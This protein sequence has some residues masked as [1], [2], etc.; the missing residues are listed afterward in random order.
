MCLSDPAA[1]KQSQMND[2]AIYFRLRRL[3]NAMQNTPRLQCMIRYIGIELRDD[4]IGA[5]QCIA[6]M[7]M[8]ID[9]I[10]AIG[11]IQG[12]ARQIRMLPPILP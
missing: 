4:R 7:P 8:L 9:G 11:A 10:L 5:Q 1:V 3:Q 2:I 12:V 6:M